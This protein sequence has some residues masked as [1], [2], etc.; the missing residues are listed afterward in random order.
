MATKAQKTVVADDNGYAFHKFAWFAQDGTLLTKKFRS[1][2][3][4]GAD[5]FSDAEGN[6]MWRYE[7]AG[8]TYSCTPAATKPINVRNADYPLSDANRVLVAHGLS[9]CGLLGVPVQLAV[10]LPLRDFYQANGQINAARKDDVRDNYLNVPVKVVGKDAQPQ[11]ESVAVLAECMSA[12]FDWALS[13]MGDLKDEIEEIGAM[14]IVDIGGETTDILSVSYHEGRLVI[15][16]KSSGTKR[17]GVLDA[18][19]EVK[20]HALNRIREEGGRVESMDELPTLAGE[21]LL[22]RGACNFA[23]RKWEMK[24]IRDQVLSAHSRKLNDY[25]SETLGSLGNYGLILVVGGGAV[26]YKEPLQ[27]LLPHAE[28]GDEWANAK[29][30]AKYLRYVASGA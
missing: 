23:G 10:T 29:G 27:A 8:S 22:Q 20:T 24:D 5:G 17:I 2:V 30:A 21:Q 1:V 26:V 25:I 9:E 11:I 18:L 12:W 6:V 4:Q 14:A 19:R 15:D 7:T 3:E 13:D 28:F 16:N